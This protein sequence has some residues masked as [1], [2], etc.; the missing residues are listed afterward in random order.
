[1]PGLHLLPAPMDVAVWFDR[2]VGFTNLS[3][4]CGI[5]IFKVTW[6]T[7]GNGVTITSW[8]FPVKCVS[9]CHLERFGLNCK[10]ASQKAHFVSVTKI[11][12]LITLKDIICAFVR[13]V[14]N[15]CRKY[16]AA[17]VQNFWNVKVSDTYKP[18]WPPNREQLPTRR[19]FHKRMFPSFWWL[20]KYVLCPANPLSQPGRWGRL[21]AMTSRLAHI[22]RIIL[23]A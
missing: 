3:E 18:L 19:C 23:S 11:N 16:T 8:I 6:C 12:E 4:K 10:L 5:S 21:Y 7:T 1:M 22:Q 14:R 2:L 20:R 15:T 17:A 13:I 9:S